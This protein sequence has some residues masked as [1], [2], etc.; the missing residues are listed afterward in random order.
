M[1]VASPEGVQRARLRDM[2]ESARDRAEHDAMTSCETVWGL[3]ALLSAAFGVLAMVLGILW[4]RL[5]RR[6]KR[7]GLSADAEQLARRRD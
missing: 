5:E 6:S 1:A 2:P 3:F 4:L 7:E